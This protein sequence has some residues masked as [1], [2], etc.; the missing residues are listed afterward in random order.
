LTFLKHR[1]L[2]RVARSDMRRPDVAGRIMLP[3]M[4]QC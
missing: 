2:E 3:A 4:Q 1:R